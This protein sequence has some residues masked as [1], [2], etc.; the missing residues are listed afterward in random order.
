[1]LKNLVDQAH[2]SFGRLELGSANI[3]DHVG[4]SKA[5]NRE[6]WELQLGQLGRWEEKFEDLGGQP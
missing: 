2:V 5:G 6:H 3:L 4:R 1:M